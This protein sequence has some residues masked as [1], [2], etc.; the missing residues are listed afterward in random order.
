MQSGIMALMA[1]HLSVG[2]RENAGL[3]QK[4]MG[5]IKEF[6]QKVKK[7]LQIGKRLL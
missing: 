4:N 7:I 5:N 3:F 6:L 2:Y 1:I